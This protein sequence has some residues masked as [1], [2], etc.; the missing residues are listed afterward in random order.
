MG[1]KPPSMR[2]LSQAQNDPG[3]R[4]QLPP[5]TDNKVPVIYGHVIT[6]GILTHANISNENKTMTYVLVLSE[7]TGNTVFTV[8]NLY[9]NDETMAFDT[10]GGILTLTDSDGTINSNVAG[11]IRCHVYQGDSTANTSQVFPT[12]NKVAA[13]TLATVLADD[14]ASMNGLVYAV[15]S[16]DYDPGNDLVQLGT[17]NF[18]IESDLFEPSNVLIDYATNSRY[19]AGLTEAELELSS[20]DDMRAYSITQVDYTPHDSTDTN[21][22]RWRIDGILSTYQNVKSNIDKI[23]QSASTWFTYDTKSGKFSVVPNRAWTAP[24]LANCFVF[25]DDNIVGSFDISTTDLYSLYNVIEAEH[26]QYTMRDQTE[27]SYVE[28]PDASRN[29]NEPENKLVTRYDMVNDNTRVENLAAIDLRQSRFSTVIQFTAD[30]SAMQV[31][32]GDVV[33]INNSIYS[34]TDELFRVI[35]I[36]E[37]EGVSG[38]ITIK[39]TLL[40]Y[41]IAVYD[42]SIILQ[43]APPVNT[44]IINYHNNGDIIAVN[45]GALANSVLSG[46]PANSITSYMI[47][48]PDLISQTVF[49]NIANSIVI[50]GNDVA[51]VYIDIGLIESDLANIN[52]PGL[53][54]NISTNAN[55]ISTLTT[56]TIPALEIE[57]SDN[58]NAIVINA[59]DITANE[60]S[61]GYVRY[62][63]LPAL[64]ADLISTDANVAIVTS[65]LG[66]LAI[67]LGD[68]FPIITTSITDGAITT[69]K[70]ATNAVTADK[71]LANTITANKIAAG[72]ITAIEI[73][74]STITGAKIAAG[75][76][77]STNILAGSISAAEIGAGAITTSKI[78]AGNVTADRIATGTITATQIAAGTITATQIAAGTIT[79]AKIAAGTITSTEIATGAITA[80]KIGAGEVTTDKLGALSIT[81]A[82]INSGAITADKLGALSV[83]AGKIDSG[84]VTTDTMT[85]NSINANRLTASTL[86]VDKIQSGTSATTGGLVFGLGAGATINGLYASGIF[87]STQASTYGIIGASTTIDGVVGG[88]V[89]DGAYGVA[90]FG[91]ADTSFS[92]ASWNYAGT[93]GGYD[94]GIFATNKAGTSTANLA[95]GLYAGYF[96]GDVYT[97]G[98]YL[99]FTGSHEGLLHNSS[100]PVPGDIMVD[101]EV[102]AKP[103]ISDTLVKMTASTVPNQKGVIGVYNTT[104]PNNHI[105]TTLS[106]ITITKSQSGIPKHIL[107][108]KPE[109][110]QMLAS[111]KVITVNALGEG[112]LNVIGE[113]G[114]ISIGDLI[115]TSSTDGKGMKQSDDIIRSYT[116]AKSRE[117][118]TFNDLLEVKMIACV[119]LAG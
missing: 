14:A 68:A 55:N 64:D 44:G 52:I 80:V 87:K 27:V 98:S 4:I 10:S 107:S 36:D 41:N 96:G 66:N 103:G 91:G 116:V 69:P 50:L 100:N 42:H 74:A 6:G 58:A 11:K 37:Q 90:G 13:N 57:L 12:T 109:Y 113:N 76:I 94:S 63:M 84:A 112:Q 111:H 53:Q 101:V 119:Y 15:I 8:N 30:Y 81:S 93:L 3:V 71:I 9:R 31:D 51:N 24:E 110:A 82:Q 33:K 95:T 62:T 2:G 115:V 20:F 104:M 16:M 49:T 59:S 38:D 86:T 47:D 89:I 34:Y 48:V 114:N 7:E 77:T 108:I 43:K 56:V 78:A 75:T 65:D 21:Q 22:D 1:G 73:A 72:T 88:A 28:I 79:A 18:D 83:I 23:C 39:V 25:S 70:I 26:P 92:S 61:I 54:A 85:A 45:D 35:R 117:N 60:S 46:L 17:I 19:G 32:V 105:P 5:G 118:V 106:D 40:E 97:T 99:P 29:T 102:M 67:E